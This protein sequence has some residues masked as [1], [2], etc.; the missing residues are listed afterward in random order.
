MSKRKIEG[1]L[2]AR[3]MLRDES[4][5]SQKPRTRHTC[6]IKPPHH[7]NLKASTARSR[8]AVNERVP[9]CYGLMVNERVRLVRETDCSGAGSDAC[10]ECDVG[11]ARSLS[12]Y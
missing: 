5:H 6:I 12:V 9:W 4:W 7:G 11:L 3:S 2:S 10:C 1:A 8:D